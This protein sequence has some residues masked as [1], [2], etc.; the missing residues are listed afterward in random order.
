MR[1]GMNSWQPES[2]GVIGGL[3]DGADDIPGISEA[4]V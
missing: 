2:P 1:G 3:P 4:H